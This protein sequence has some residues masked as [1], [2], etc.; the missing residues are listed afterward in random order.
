MPNPI[1]GMFQSTD[2][3]GYSNQ[4]MMAIGDIIKAMMYK[5]AVTDPAEEWRRLTSMEYRK[6][7]QAEDERQEFERQQMPQMPATPPPAAPPSPMSEA[8]PSTGPAPPSFGAR[9]QPH[10]ADE[11]MYVQDEVEPPYPQGGF[12]QDEILAKFKEMNPNLDWDK[13][14]QQAGGNV[15]GGTFSQMPSSPERE[16][17][18]AS[19]MEYVENQIPRDEAMRMLDNRSRAYNPEAAEMLLGRLGNK[20][21]NAADMLYSKAQEM[22]AQAEMEQAQAMTR[23][24]DMMSTP[25]GKLG[26]TIEMILQNLDPTMNGQIY[27]L[28]INAKMALDAGDIDAA[29]EIMGQINY[30]SSGELGGGELQSSGG[31]I[32]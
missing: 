23:Q 17:Q 10:S 4:D 24:Y 3:G 13:V 31:R 5:S 21:K 20:E 27:N 28:A 15:P 29:R 16:A 12:K 8:G 19:L 9:L 14:A 11:S 2:N 18:V 7:A 26:S 6:Q 30:M 1:T 22:K 25:E 32:G